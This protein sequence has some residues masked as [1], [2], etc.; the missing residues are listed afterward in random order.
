[1]GFWK[2]RKKSVDIF[3]EISAVF[4]DNL[5]KCKEVFFPVCSIRLGD[6]NKE[7]G[8]EKI[9][10]VQF[11]EDPYNEDTSQHFTPYCKDA[12]IA[13]DVAEGRY[14]FRADFGYFELSEEW[15]EWFEATKRTY[16][17][18]KKEY[19]DT[20]KTFGI[21]LMKLGGNPD[22]WQSDETPLAPDGSP[23]K[24]ITSFETDSICNDYCD[25][26]IFLFY[27]RKHKLAVQIYQI[28]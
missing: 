22:W 24:F 12:M 18:S 8:D 17:E 21:D 19:L 15:K 27:S 3:P 28:T 20:G 26:K 13:F 14:K 16:T 25:K 4:S 1:M 6:V 7:W 5:D 23:M 2:K 9:H 11:N 10:L